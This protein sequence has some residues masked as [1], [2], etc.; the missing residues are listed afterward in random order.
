MNENQKNIIKLLLNE[1]RPLTSIQISEKLNLSTRTI[2]KII[3]SINNLYINDLIYISSSTH[4]GYW[5][6]NEQKT[7]FQELLIS[8]RTQSIPTNQYQRI[9]KV[10]FQLL[11]GT[12]FNKTAQA[13][14]NEMYVSKASISNDMKVFKE[15][16]TT[17]EEIDFKSLKNGG[18]ELI[19][20]EEGLRYLFTVLIYLLYEEETDFIEYN[21]VHYFSDV[22]TSNTLSELIIP[23]FLEKNFIFND[24][25]MH[26]IIM[27]LQF[28]K[29]RSMKGFKLAENSLPDAPNWFTS[30][31]DCLNIKFDKNERNYI[32]SMIQRRLSHYTDIQKEVIL[33]E[34]SFNIIQEYYDLLKNKY[35]IVIEDNKFKNTLY[36]FLN[37]HYFSTTNKI[38]EYTSIDHLFAKTL[39]EEF[40]N[41]AYRHNKTNFSIDSVDILTAYIST[42][43]DGNIQRKKTIIL[44][45]VNFGHREYMSYRLN[46]RFSFY[47][48]FI[49]TLPLYS[50]NN[51]DLF[52]DCEL[53]IYT[54]RKVLSDSRSFKLIKSLGIDILFINPALGYE[55]FHIV[56][57]YL[58]TTLPSLKGYAPKGITTGYFK[59]KR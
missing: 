2:K 28:Y 41:I 59:Q 53:I 58:H 39:S 13:L 44:S 7:K 6:E 4:A 54:S 38:P 51:I 56:D 46:T 48:E 33:M 57:H 14:A 30:I 20:T 25:D 24:K 10:G 31:E 8:Y 50:I 26:I 32:Y 12:S 21:A 37:Y 45:D 18:Y 49:Q 52:K 40:L 17:V 22:I 9:I 1:N 34:E 35:D 47:L 16:C 3:T 11:R 42:I 36:T 55:D 27:E 19:G 15:I 23:L 43:L 29:Y 5:I